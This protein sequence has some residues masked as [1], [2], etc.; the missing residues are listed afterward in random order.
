MIGPPRGMQAICPEA[1]VLSS[2]RSRAANLGIALAHKGES[3]L[4]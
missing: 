2:I 1:A 3:S 4:I